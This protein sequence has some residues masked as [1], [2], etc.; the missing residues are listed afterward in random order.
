[1]SIKKEYKKGDDSLMKATNKKDIIFKRNKALSEKVASALRS[2]GFDAYICDTGDEAAS[3]VLSIIPEGSSVSWGGSYSIQEIGLVDKIRSGNYR[4]L[5]RDATATP[6]KRWEMMIKALSADV[7]LTSFNAVSE[8]GILYN[9][10]GI[11][12]RIAAIIYG[13][14][15]VVAIVGMNKVCPTKEDAY[16]R[17]RG[18]AA[19]VNA[20]RFGGGTPC[21]ATGSCEDCRSPDSICS[22]IVETR[23]C[24]PAGRIK[25]ILV[26]EELGI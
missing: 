22:H 4:V 11:G 21:V 12:N 15:M 13:P 24:R 3:L 20:A 16:A 5:D 6:E 9:I 17:A 19:P 23:M 14:R 18:Y 1:M 8:D 2:R 25:I 26:K 10:D 7:F